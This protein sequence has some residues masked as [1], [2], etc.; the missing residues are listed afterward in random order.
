MHLPSELHLYP[1]MENPYFELG[2]R[3]K[4]LAA[5]RAADIQTLPGGRWIVVAATC[6]HNSAYVVCWDALSPP[7][8]GVI[9]PAATYRTDWSSRPD[10]I[11]TIQ[12]DYM[13]ECVN[14]LMCSGEF[15]DK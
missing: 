8:S 9:Y 1:S 4:P 2:F 10:P 7:E 15:G 5:T 6:P 11:L 14:I 13:D 3:V 12:Y